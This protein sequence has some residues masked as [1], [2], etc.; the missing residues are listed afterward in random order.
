METS[1]TVADQHLIN[2]AWKVP[3]TD[4]EEVDKMI[5]QAQSIQAKKELR[6]IRNSLHHKEEFRNGNL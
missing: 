1:M 2:Q 3:Y 6:L 5:D 4:W